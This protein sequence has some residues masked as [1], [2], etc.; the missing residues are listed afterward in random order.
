MPIPLWVSDYW[1]YLL[2]P[3]DG[4][5][6]TIPANSPQ[7]HQWLKTTLTLP[8]LTG[9]TKI[10]LLDYYPQTSPTNIA[11]ITI[12]DNLFVFVNPT[13][14]TRD[15]IDAYGGTS[16]VVGG[17]PS[18]LTSRIPPPTAHRVDWTNAPETGWYIDPLELPLGDFVPGDN[19]VY[20]LLEEFC[21]W[22]GLGHL[23]F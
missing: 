9:I 19:T 7:I 8:S 16:Q 2:Y 1:A 13:G 20:V 10:E 18:A 5:V 21:S 17:F 11:K 23:A 22:G 12:N 6:C 14:F 3:S 15:D 4:S